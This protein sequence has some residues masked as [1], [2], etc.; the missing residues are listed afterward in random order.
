MANQGSNHSGVPVM[1]P[2]A[3]PGGAL[4]ASGG[5]SSPMYFGPPQGGAPEILVGG[6]NQTWLTNCLRRRFILAILMG[7]LVGAAIAGL[8]LWLFPE[9]ASTKAYLEVKVRQ[10]GVFQRDE[11][12]SPQE[13]EKRAM[14]QLALIKSQFVL[15]NALSRPDISVLQAVRDQGTLNDAVQWMYEDL[16]ASFPSDG[17]ILEVKYEGEEDPEEMEKIVQAIVES[18]REEAVYKEKQKNAESRE[19]KSQVHRDLQNR[20]QRK[21][22]EY[23]GLVDVKGNSHSPTAEVETMKLQSDLRMLET[24]I[25]KIRGEIL[26]VDVFKTV[27]IAT[28]DNPTALDAQI[29]EALASDPMIGSY[30]DQLFAMQQQMMELAARSQNP[31]S[32]DLRRLKTQISQTERMLSSYRAQQERQLREQ[33]KNIPKEGLRAVMVEWQVRRGELTRRLEDLEGQVSEKER[34]LIELGARDPKLDMLKA[35]IESQQATVAEL[36]FE[37]RGWEVDAG[38]EEKRIGVLNPATATTQIN[39]IERY[40]LAGIGGLGP[41]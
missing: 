35:E 14:T 21:M 28:A 34:R 3:G 27:A 29:Q 23:E 40:S 8:L 12:V 39:T 20:L 26:D 1:Q 6:F 25:S 19:A 10:E 4:V 18:Y 16:Q 30:E 15:Q 41:F 7:L 37:L 9:S 33:L 5:V 2:P 24:E 11:R 32:P 17:E 38:S 36:S 13:L 31:N 22:E